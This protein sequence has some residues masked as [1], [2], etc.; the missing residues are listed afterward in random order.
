MKT[1]LIKITMP[2][3]SQGKAFGIFSSS[4]AAIIQVMDDFPAAQRISA[5]R[6]P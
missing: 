4:C 6:A 5:R 3:G 2:D 1:Y